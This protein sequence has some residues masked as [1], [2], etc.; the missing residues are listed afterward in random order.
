MFGFLPLVGTTCGQTPGGS[1]SADPALW[2]KVDAGSSCG[3]NGCAVTS[4]ADP[5]PNGNVAIGFNSPTMEQGLHNFDAGITCNTVP[6]T[7]STSR[8]FDVTDGF[9]NFT[10]GISAFEA[11]RPIAN[12]SWE[13]SPK[14]PQVA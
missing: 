5:G 9:D 13:R 14:F 8:H 1:P 3:S 2:L 12:A 7:A 11:A 4:W 10:A 6:S